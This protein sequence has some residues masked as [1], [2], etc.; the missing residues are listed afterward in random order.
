[1]TKNM[2]TRIVAVALLAS[3]AVVACAISAKA[4]VSEADPTTF[5]AYSDAIKSCGAKWKAREDRTTD[6]GMAAWQT[7][8]AACV[9]EAGFRKGSK[10]PK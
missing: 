3:T 6:K 7:F 2:L 9:Q 10:K 4:A 1:M 5:V 8:R